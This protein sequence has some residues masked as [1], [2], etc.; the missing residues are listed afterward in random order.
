[1]AKTP[2]R[3]DLDALSPIAWVQEERRRQYEARG[4]QDH[5][6][7]KWLAVLAE[8]FGEVA[9]ALEDGHEGK[10][11]HPTYTNQ[12]EYELIQVAAVAVAWVE[13]IRRGND[14][15]LFPWCGCEECPMEKNSEE[16]A[17]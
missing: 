15:S 14:S 17:I 6:P 9:K 3:M 7:L 2:S 10:H 5:N 12:L 1:M 16:A 13:A 11:D 8:E 4:D